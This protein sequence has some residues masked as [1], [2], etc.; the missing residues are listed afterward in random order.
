[1]LSTDKLTFKR[2]D[3]LIPAVAVVVAGIVLALNVTRSQPAEK[4]AE[5]RA[6]GETVALLPLDEDA[7]VVYEAGDGVNRVTVQGGKV[8]VSEADCR[9]QV[10][11]R[12]RA[13][14]RVGESIVCAP[15]GLIVTVVGE[16]GDDA[17]DLIVR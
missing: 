15:H 13:I 1:M 10:C 16:G 14:S 17:P 2:F 8:S 11:V 9:T 6:G 12:S 5:I 7:D 4:Y 3:L